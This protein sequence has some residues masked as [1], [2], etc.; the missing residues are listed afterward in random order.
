MK[1]ISWNHINLGGDIEL[2]NRIAAIFI[3]LMKDK[4]VECKFVCARINCKEEFG[5]SLTIKIKPPWS[6][7]EFYSNL[8]IFV[9]R[10]NNGFNLLDIKEFEGNILWPN[11]VETNAISFKLGQRTQEYRLRLV[12]LLQLIQLI[13]A[14][15]STNT[16]RVKEIIMRLKL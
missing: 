10:E 13:S 15:D 11:I 8:N 12:D 4:N 3:K 1:K 16:M 7:S 9:C 5:G 6:A 2:I 14:H